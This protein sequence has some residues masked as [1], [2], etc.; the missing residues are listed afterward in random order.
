MP[1][2]ARCA[3]HISTALIGPVSVLLALEA[4]NHR[5]HIWPDFFL[6]IT[7]IDCFRHF[8]LE[9]YLNGHGLLYL[10]TNFFANSFCGCNALI[11]Q[12][13]EDFFILYFM[14]N[15]HDDSFRGANWFPLLMATSMPQNFVWSA[16]DLAC[17]GLCAVTIR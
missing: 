5:G 14:G 4:P 10:A 9:S 17:L 1:L 6:F 11:F 3:A 7:V 2:P 13:C 8:C 15:S 12:S 16:I